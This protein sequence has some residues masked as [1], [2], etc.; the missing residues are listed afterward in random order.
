MRSLKSGITLS[1]IAFLFTFAVGE[2]IF[3][4]LGHEPRRIIVEEEHDPQWSQPAPVVGWINRRGKFVSGE[5]GAAIMSFTEDGRRFD[6]AENASAAH[7][8]YIFGDSFSQGYGVDDFSTYSHFLNLKLGGVVSNFGVG[9]YGAYQS[10]LRMR[11][12]LSDPDKVRPKLVIYSLIQH[13]SSRDAA[14]LNWILSL[15]TNDRAWYVPPHLRYSRSGNSW[16]EMPAHEIAIWPFETR[17]ASIA[18]LHKAFLGLT[19]DASI[20]EGK[21]ATLHAI[22]LMQEEADKYGVRFLLVILE[23][24]AHRSIKIRFN[25]DEIAHLRCVQ[26]DL[27]SNP[28]K[29]TQYYG[30]PSVIA[31]K[32]WAECIGNWIKQN[33]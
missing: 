24:T 10:L 7:K 2:I 16:I 30:H 4:F 32:E 23:G 21:A 22:K 8:I 1:I 29:T 3:R 19:Y 27:Y 12:V 11:Q 25:Q 28:K 26:D 20:E 18:A 6:P 5:F 33:L 31:H 9:G 15:S 17:L 14:L 13:H